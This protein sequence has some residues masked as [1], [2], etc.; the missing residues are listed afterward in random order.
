MNK[1]LEGKN[2][3]ITGARRGMGRAMTELFAS[4]G[5]NIWACSHS[6]SEEF[7]EDMKLLSKNY[8]VEIVPVYFDLSDQDDIKRGLKEIF[9]FKK[10]INILVNNA[11]ITHRALFQMT[12]VQRAREVF[13]VD[14]FAPY[15]IMQLVVKRMTKN[16][17]GASVINISSTAGIDANAGRAAYG[18]A[19]SALTCLTRVVAE[20]VGIQ[21]IRVNAIAPGITAT[22]MLTY[23]EEMLKELVEESLLKKIGK[24]SDI[25]NAAL[26]LA[27]DR[28]SFI[29]GQIIRVDGGMLK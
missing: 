29:T 21:G 27:S 17:N 13:E 19:K 15:L 9:L 18:S 20:E 23:S 14:F 26:F 24:P 25:A 22:E 10:E 6:P 8:G 3:I 2:A 12:T 16:K 7:E 28:S 5:A 11:G 4:N 1:L